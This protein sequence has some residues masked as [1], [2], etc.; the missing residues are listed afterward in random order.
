MEKNLSFSKE[1]MALLE[2]KNSNNTHFQINKNFEN[3]LL[4]FSQNIGKT[5]KNGLFGYYLKVYENQFAIQKV[6]QIAI[7]NNKIKRM[8]FN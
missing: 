3:N 6:N 5:I 7:E 8:I 1:A 2:N 4:F